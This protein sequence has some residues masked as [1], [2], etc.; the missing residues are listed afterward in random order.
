VAPTLHAHPLTFSGIRQPLMDPIGTWVDVTPAVLLAV[1]LLPFTSPQYGCQT[2]G[3]SPHN[4]AV[5]YCGCCYEGIFRSADYGKTWTKVSTGTHGSDLD[6]GRPWALAVDP[7]DENTL[8]TVA[9][10]G[11]G[12]QGVF[13]STDGGV[14]YTQMMDATTISNSSADIYCITI[15]PANHNH[16]LISFHS[17]WPS[18]SDTGVGETT[19]GGSTWA[20]HGPITGVGSGCYIFFLGQDDSGVASSNYWLLTTQS[21]G[22]WRTTNGGSTWTQVH[23]AHSMQHGGEQLYRSGTGVLYTGCAGAYM[24]RSTDN[25]QTWTAI[26]NGS[27][28]LPSTPDGYN[29]VFGDG[30]YIYCCLTNTGVATNTPVSWYYTLDGDGLNWTQ[31]NTQSFQDGPM[32]GAVDV[33]NQVVYA[34]CWCQGILRLK[35]GN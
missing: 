22:Y 5:I 29:A 20:L 11:S 19:D 2:I 23:S 33:V 15:D 3:L 26:G 17:P 27:N 9:G 25:G 6:L 32:S 35:T 30:V 12:A 13:K 18:S 34:S 4:P 1:P 21:G 31:Y 8:Y 24:I 16:V 14:N 7:T 28:G 10:F